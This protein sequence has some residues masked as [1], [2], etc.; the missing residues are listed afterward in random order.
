MSVADRIIGLLDTMTLASLNELNR[1]PVPA[2]G[3]DRRE[4]QGT[5]SPR[6]V[7]R[8]PRLACSPSCATDNPPPRVRAWLPSDARPL[9]RSQL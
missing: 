1:G 7:W 2:L 9:R 6:K 5:R 8:S 4:A 3:Q